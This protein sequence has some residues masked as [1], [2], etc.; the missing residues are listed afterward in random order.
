MNLKHSAEL[1]KSKDGEVTMVIGLFGLQ[2]SI[3][4]EACYVCKTKPLEKRDER[5]F[6]PM[7]AKSYLRVIEILI[8]LLH[9]T[10]QKTKQ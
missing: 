8:L 6:W 5:N 3:N 1:M 2:D 10:V 4:S 7:L 9:T